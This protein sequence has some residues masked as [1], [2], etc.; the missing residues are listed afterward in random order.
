MQDI[1]SSVDNYAKENDVFLRKLTLQSK[2]GGDAFN[3]AP[4]MLELNVYEDINSPFMT[5]DLI[6][7]DGEALATNFPIIGNEI[8]DIEFETPTSKDPLKV[9]LDVFGIGDVKRSES[10]K[11]EAYRLGLIGPAYMEQLSQRVAGSYRGQVSAIAMAVHGRYL[12]NRV[13][14]DADPSDE[15]R[16]L[17]VPFLTPFETLAWLATRAIGISSHASYKCWEDRD[18]IHFKDLCRMV[19]KET[20]F[21]YSYKPISPFTSSSL[22]DHLSNMKDYSHDKL[23]DQLDAIDSGMYGSSVFT[24]NITTMSILGDLSDYNREFSTAPHLNDKPLWP[25]SNHSYS[26]P[27]TSPSMAFEHSFAFGSAFPRDRQGLAQN[28]RQT[29]ISNFFAMQTT[30]DVPGDTRLRIGNVVEL[31]FTKNSPLKPG[32]AFVDPIRS[33]RYV[34]TAIRHMLNRSGHVMTVECAKDSLIQGL[35]DIIERGFQ[36]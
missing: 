31:T 27:L 7:G 6:M 28:T 20:R 1:Y 10:E 17:I 13:G 23:F 25:M 32:D 2:Q 9:K 30:F 34:V 29:A 15:I 36:S 21:S 12:K 8:L 24:Y 14:F 16:Q 4:Q 26:N 3:L 19:Q 35:P 18:G 33:G 11:F 22:A 5:G